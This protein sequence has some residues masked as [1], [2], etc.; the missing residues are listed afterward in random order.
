MVHTTSICEHNTSALS[1]V[2][3]PSIQRCIWRS[4]P[5]KAS[6]FVTSAGIW[7]SIAFKWAWQSF[8]IGLVFTHRQTKT[9][10][11]S[12]IYIHKTQWVVTSF[13]YLSWS[14]LDD[15]SLSDSLFAVM[16]HINRHSQMCLKREN[17]ALFFHEA[18]ANWSLA[19]YSVSF[20]SCHI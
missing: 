4:H 10:N 9:V 16:L 18:Q 13:G 1:A 14:P 5:L 7:I 6:L 11:D 19:C 17:R 20:S 12:Y 15:Y 2:F 8:T 3:F